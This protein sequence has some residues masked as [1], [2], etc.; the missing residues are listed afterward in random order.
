[1]KIEDFVKQIVDGPGGF[2][3]WE[4]REFVIH[5]KGRDLSLVSWVIRCLANPKCEGSAYVLEQ[6][7]LRRDELA[8]PASSLIEKTTPNS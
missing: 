5:K 2:K 1:M 6:I 4:D 7:A 8:A 3:T